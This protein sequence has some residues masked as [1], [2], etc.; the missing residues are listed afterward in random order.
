M[1]RGERIV[2][3]ATDDC[4]K[5]VVGQGI[6][7]MHR[8]RWYRHGSFEDPRPSV[9]DRFWSKVD[10]TAGA[11]GCWLWLAKVNWRGYGEFRGG[12]GVSMSAHRWAVLSDGRDIPD[13]YHVDHLCRVKTCVNPRHLEVVTAAENIRRGVA[14]RVR[15]EQQL[16]KTHCPLGHPYTEENTGYDRKGGRWCRECKR[17]YARRRYALARG[18]TPEDPGAELRCC[19]T[20]GQPLPAGLREQRF[21]APGHEQAT[22]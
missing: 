15:G 21:R 2:C 8:S 3:S 1:Q 17:E 4:T 5:P 20:C 12:E 22:T 13:G 16:R 11:E 10:R 18:R 19:R 14:G 6:C 7:A 9:A